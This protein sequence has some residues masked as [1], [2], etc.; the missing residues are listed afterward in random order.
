MDGKLS[1]PQWWWKGV[2]VAG[3][4]YALYAGAVATKGMHSHRAVQIVVAFDDPFFLADGSGG[5]CVCEAAVIPSGV[6]HEIV[7][8][9]AR[10]LLLYVAPEWFA[11]P[12]WVMSPGAGAGEW[13][14]LSRIAGLHEIGGALRDWPRSGLAAARSI[15]ADNCLP[16]MNAGFIGHPA[17]RELMHLLPDRLAGPVRLADLA[18]DIGISKDRL[19][20]VIRSD[21]GV[22]FRRYVL[23]LRLQR[24]LELCAAGHSITDAAHDTGFADSAHFSRACR[25]LLGF[26]PSKLLRY[27]RWI[28]EDALGVAGLFKREPADAG[29]DWPVTATAWLATMLPVYSARVGLEGAT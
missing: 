28:P 23:S 1:E 8:G 17:V 25:H 21:L 19:A 18:G 6:P 2:A 24:A 22:P 4:G 11:D 14:A 26:V 13:V 27:I 12:T 5:A 10:G 20:H 16:R 3:P 29:D 15:M 9:T 7:R